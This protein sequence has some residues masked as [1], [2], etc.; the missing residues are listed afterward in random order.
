MYDVIII[1]GGPAG[2]SCALNCL[3]N[4]KSVLILEKENF[5]GQIAKSPRLENY[6]AIEKISG[7]DFSDQLFEQ[8][9]NLGVEFELE[10]VESVKK[11]DNKFIVKTDYN[12]H[13]GKTVVIATGVEHRKMG[14]EREEELVGHGV[15]YCATC[16]GA[17]FKGQDVV[18]IGDAN[19]ALQYAIALA[20]Y[21]KSVKI[22]AL[23][24]H[25]FADKF[26]I[27]LLDTK[28]NLTYQFNLNLKSLDGEKELTGLTFIDTKT[29]EQVKILC[30]GVFIAIGQIADNDKFKDYVDLDHG[31]IITND[32]METKTSGLYSIGDCTKK[33]VRQVVTALSDG[34]IAA[35]SINK[36]LA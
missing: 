24:D 36:Y 23:F 5:G 19:S 10:N 4:G 35:V 28:P 31:F 17:F 2:M 33:D 25:W 27:D 3:R 34:A 29:K 22:C 32:K 30:K 14:I 9:N 12:E 6:P 7:L 11:I 16:D 8:I 26:L 18:V 13:E 15:S 20:D 21:C 1:G